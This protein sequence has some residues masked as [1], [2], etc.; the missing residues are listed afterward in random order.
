[1]KGLNISLRAPEPADIDLIYGWENDPEIWQVSNTLTPY[2]R[3]DI[4]QFVLHQRHDLFAS[5]QLRLMIVTNADKF[6]IGAIDLFDFEPLHRRAGVGIL[7][8]REQRQKGVASEALQ[9]LTAYCFNTLNLH[10]LYCHI[11][12]D[13]QPSIDL[14]SKSGFE[15]SGI[16]KHW[17]N[18]GGEWKDV[19]FMQLI[20]SKFS[21]V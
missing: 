12:P 17:I 14:F 7:V 5:K 11:T 19:I 15:R 8:T 16:C 1:M 9:L 21:K 3:Y 20:N 6:T 13:N 10:Q 2:S 18:H 4:E